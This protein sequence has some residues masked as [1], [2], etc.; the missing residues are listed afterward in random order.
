LAAFADHIERV[1]ERFETSACTVWS[2]RTT[3][4]MRAGTANPQWLL[5]EWRDGEDEPANY[6]RGH[7]RGLSDTF[8]TAS[9][10]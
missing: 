10:R 2:S 8:T 6:F 4:E 7:R 5:I 9:S 1:A 3:M